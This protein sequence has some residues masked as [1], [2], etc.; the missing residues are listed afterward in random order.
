MRGLCKHRNDVSKPRG[1]Y[2]AL[3]HTALLW[4]QNNENRPGSMCFIFIFQI[5]PNDSHNVFWGACICFQCNCIRMKGRFSLPTCSISNNFSHPLANVNC[6][7]WFMFINQNG[8]CMGSEESR[9]RLLSEAVIN[10]HW[11]TFW[12]RLYKNVEKQMLAGNQRRE[13]KARRLAF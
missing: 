7:P 13:V 5:F 2:A 3:K 12:V 4:D 1:A 9:S 8:K 6:H 10:H 11:L